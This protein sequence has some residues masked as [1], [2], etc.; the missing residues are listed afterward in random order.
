[1][2]ALHRRR[3]RSARRGSVLKRSA[4]AGAVRVLAP[5]RVRDPGAWRRHRSLRRQGQ[6]LNVGRA[7][8]HHSRSAAGQGPKAWVAQI[9]CAASGSKRLAP[10][11]GTPQVPWVTW[12]SAGELVTGLPLGW[13]LPCQQL[14]GRAGREMSARSPL[15]GLPKNPLCAQRVVARPCCPSRRSSRRARGLEWSRPGNVRSA[16]RAGSVSSGYG[17]SRM[18]QAPLL[19]TRLLGDGVEAPAGDDDAGADRAQRGAARRSA[20]WGC[21]CRGRS[22]CGRTCRTGSCCRGKG[23]PAARARRRCSASW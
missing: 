23:P 4:L 13:K 11:L 2:A 17:T 19:V 12:R 6:H 3:I 8:I 7:R 20:R 14:P 1:M 5:R 10:W 9:T 15:V 18:P 22:C 16:C 21:C